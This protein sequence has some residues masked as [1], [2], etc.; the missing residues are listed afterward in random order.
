MDKIFLILARNIRFLI[1]AFCAG[2]M[3]KLSQ[4]NSQFLDPLK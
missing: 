1:I 3:Y 2:Y 4:L